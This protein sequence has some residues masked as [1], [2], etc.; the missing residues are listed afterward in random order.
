M[1][2]RPI[3]NRPWVGGTLKTLLEAATALTPDLKGS[4]FAH[5]DP[6]RL[7]EDERSKRIVEEYRNLLQL[8][9]GDLQGSPAAARARMIQ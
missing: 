6:L 4:L 8:R 1:S 5:V 3:P 9:S 2:R 7:A